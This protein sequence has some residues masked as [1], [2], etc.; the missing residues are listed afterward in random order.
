MENAFHMH[1]QNPPHTRWREKIN[2]THI[3]CEHFILMIYCFSALACEQSLSGFTRE[4]FLSARC[5]REGREVG[6]KKNGENFLTQLLLYGIGPTLWQALQR[7]DNYSRHPSLA[8]ICTRRRQIGSAWAFYSFPINFT[9]G[10]WK[11]MVEAMIFILASMKWIV[12]HLSVRR[13]V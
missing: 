5:S 9:T 8:Q 6:W 3:H 13:N 11:A 4:Y 2:V 7:F 10:E 12:K 1:T